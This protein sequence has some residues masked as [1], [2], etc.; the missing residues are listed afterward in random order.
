MRVW[1]HWLRK[2]AT[3]G[4]SEGAEV[5][6]GVM[7]AVGKGKVPVRE[8]SEEKRDADDERILWVSTAKNTGVRFNVTERKLRRDIPILVRADEEDM[9]VSYEIEYDGMRPPLLDIVVHANSILQNFSFER[10][11][12]CSCWRSPW[13]KRTILQAKRSYLARSGSLF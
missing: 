10:L 3:I 13:C 1:R 9:P 7:E 4:R 8:A 11:I 6:Q 2:M 12:C 5:R